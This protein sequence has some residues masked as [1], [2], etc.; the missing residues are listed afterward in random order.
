[1]L[2]RREN[3]EDKSTYE[4][5]HKKATIERKEIPETGRTHV[6]ST[7]ENEEFEQGRC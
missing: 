6:I 2:F 1:V 5:R 3:A 7:Y 4:E